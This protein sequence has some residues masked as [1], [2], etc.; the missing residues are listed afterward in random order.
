[1]SYFSDLGLAEPLL[2]ALEAKGYNDPTPIQQKSIPALIEGRDLLGLAQTGTG[3][4]AAF[5]LPSLH[6]LI[7]NPQPRKSASCRML[8]LSPTRELAAQI[9]E[10]MRGYAKF[11]N[12]SIQCIFG[13]VPAGKQARALVPGCDVLVATPGRLLDL[14]DQ[15]A[16]TLRDVEIFVLDEADQMMDL[17]FINPLKRIARLLPQQRQ[18]LFFSATMPQAIEAL[19]KQFINNPVKVEVAPQSTTAERVEQRAILISQSEKQAL[20][21]MTL[22]AGLAEGAADPIERAIIFT[23]TKHGA[24]RVVRHL[25][26]AGIEAAAIHGDKSQAQRT[27]ALK[28]FRE[29]RIKVLVATD[30][31]ARGIDVSGVSHVFNFEIP[32]VAEQYVHR[33]GR[34]ARA[35]ADGIALSF[36]AE[37]ERPYIR[38]I[39]RLT[40]VKLKILP[41]PEDFLREAARLPAPAKRTSGEMQDAARR[42]GGR[43][44]GGRRDGGRSEGGRREGSRSEGGR[45]EGGR[46]NNDRRLSVHGDRPRD[47]AR[48]QGQREADR[49]RGERRDAERRNRDGAARPAAAGPRGARPAPVRSQ[50]DPLRENVDA[51]PR[52]NG[53]R[54]Q[55]QG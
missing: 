52:G 33:I 24:D 13:G 29:N 38:A 40:G 25:T 10:N 16:F 27:A 5:S 43:R 34:T 6:R 48:S 42:D 11:V 26:P 7:T 39:E 47:G 51:A 54:R 36:V 8:V 15:R 20:L 4:T 45:R 23:R 35:G 30:I 31:A 14:I 55:R 21:T 28:G 37:D 9:A 18:S 1:M 53:Q 3:K 17:G 22:R 41:L 49:A 44:D 2:R 32:N 19:G 46:S 50:F 12:M